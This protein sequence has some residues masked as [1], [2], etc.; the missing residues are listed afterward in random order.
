MI[1]FFQTPLCHIFIDLLI[2]SGTTDVDDMFSV[3]RQIPLHHAQ[4]PKRSDGVCIICKQFR[5]FMTIN[6]IKLETIQIINTRTV[7]LT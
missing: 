3:Y 7:Y 6:S 4:T 1:L 2:F 5:Q